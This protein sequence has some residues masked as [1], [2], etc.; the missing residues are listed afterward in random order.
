MLDA[1]VRPTAPGTFYGERA[2]VFV[3]NGQSGRSNSFLVDGLD[4]NDQVS[5]TTMNAHFSQEVIREFVVLTHQYAP[6]F[7][8]ASGGVMNILTERGTNDRVFETFVQDT[9][10]GLN[11]SGDLVSSLPS[12]DQTQSSTERL[13]A[14]FKLGGPF[15]KDRAFYIAA[16]E[17]QSED[18]VVPFTGVTRDGTAGGWVVAPNHDDNVFLR[19]DFNLSDSNFL[20]LRL[21]GDRRKTRDL[22]VGGISTPETGFEL[23]EKDLQLAG[24]LTTILSPSLVNEARF[25]AGTSS[26][27]QGA[28]SSRPGVERPSGT[29]GGNNLNL[30]EREETRVQLVNNLTWSLGEHAMKFGVDLTRSRTGIHTRFNPNGNFLYN[31][32]APFEPGDCG[33]VIAS[34]VPPSYCSNDTTRSCLIDADCLGGAVCITP[35]IVCPGVPGADDDGD[36]QTDEPALMGTYAAVYQLIDGEPSATLNDTRLAL[37]AQDSWQATPKLLLDYGLR[38]DLST[39]RLPSSARVESSIP[40]GGAGL[41]T[42]NVAPRFGFTFAPWGDQ[43]LVVRGGGGIFYDK[44]VLGFPAVAAI[45]SGMQIGLLFPQGLTFELTEDLVEE[46]GIDLLKKALLFPDQLILRF[47][48]ATR[49][50]TPYAV[51]YNLGFEGALSERSAWRANLVRSLGYHQP[52]MKDLNPPVGTDPRGIPIHPDD[53]TGSIAA[54]TTEGRGWYSGLDLG[55]EWRKEGSWSAVSYTLSRSED[56]GPDPLR[57]GIYL[58]PGAFRSYIY[59]PD[60][61]ASSFPERGRSDND[62]RHRFVASGEFPL[63]WMGLRA[64]SVLQVM[65]GAPFNVTTGRD[66]NLDGVTSDRPPGVP[67]NAGEKAP[68]GPINELRAGAGLPEVR[69]LGEPTFL[70]VD[71]RVWKP[72]R[73]RDGKSSGSIF[74]QVFN[75]FDRFN[76]GPVEGRVTSREF[77]SAIGQVGPPRTVEA[78]L[79]LA[80]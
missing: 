20:M 41:D 9:L 78:G 44:L 75:L 23:S 29:F 6:E 47:S 37:F 14:G 64:S 8:R 16:Y 42:N 52:L 67:R 56:L 32:D 68:L 63:P 4:N 57:G 30:Q 80:L 69:S 26:F 58:P 49:L 33:Y 66:G 50:D 28:N 72:F 38:Y 45:T 13:Q 60:S 43:R 17:H 74:L 54:I 53:T 27:D 21:S 19:T 39:Y 73:F 5:G 62:R 48:T 35:P 40:N 76:G 7:G 59:C 18:Q 2:S 15:K 51:Q 34:Q 77:G 71:L 11:E 1:A 79:R 46:I 25:L 55:W 31:T 3:I 65:S 10:Q 36:G 61:C 70:Q 24:S 12:R 22:N